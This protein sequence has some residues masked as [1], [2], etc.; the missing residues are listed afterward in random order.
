MSYLEHSEHADALD[1]VHQPDLPTAVPTVGKPNGRLSRL[2]SLVGKIRQKLSR[3][4]YHF[5]FAWTISSAFIGLWPALSKCF[6][7]VISY[8]DPIPWEETLRD[9]D[10][11]HFTVT[12]TGAVTVE[13]W[14]SSYGRLGRVREIYYVV[15]VPTI[16]WFVSLK[17]LDQVPSL[18]ARSP[19]EH[20]W[21]IWMAEIV[22]VFF[23]CVYA[24]F[25]KS[26]QYK[27]RDHPSDNLTPG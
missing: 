4:Y 25:I 2:A 20:L 21:K 19:D 23:T 9:G 5:S 7:A 12:L 11:L 14:L 16:L 17:M 22:M 13:Y 10:W 15:V 8:N 18:I 3:D 26:F 1:G 6:S 27:Y 24:F